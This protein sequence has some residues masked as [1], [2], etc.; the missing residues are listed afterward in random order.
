VIK[1]TA[2]SKDG[3]PLLALGITD[4]NVTRLRAGLPAYVSP[5]DLQQMGLP[6]MHLM[7]VHGADERAIIHDLRQ[8]GIDLPPAVDEAVARATEGR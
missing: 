7:I 8:G 3:R 6:P 1:F 4:E 2:K 5:V